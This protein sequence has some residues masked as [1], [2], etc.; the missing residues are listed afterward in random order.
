MKWLT[1]LPFVH[2][3]QLNEYFGARR[4]VIIERDGTRLVAVNLLLTVTGRKPRLFF[5]DY[6]HGVALV[7]PV[8]WLRAAW[9]PQRPWGRPWEVCCG[10]KPADDPLESTGRTVRVYQVVKP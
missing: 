3:I 7:R 6:M 10:I 9:I 1:R 2:E 5:L 8:Y 4:G